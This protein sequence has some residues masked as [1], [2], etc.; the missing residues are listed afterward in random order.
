VFRRIVALLTLFAG[1]SAMFSALM[2][3]SRSLRHGSGV[4]VWL[5]VFPLVGL[6]VLAT[7]A[8]RR[9]WGSS[10]HWL[11][12]V[13]FLHSV[14]ALQMSRPYPQP[15]AAPLDYRVAAGGLAAIGLVLAVRWY[16]RLS[17]AGLTVDRGAGD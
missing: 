13:Y 17:L 14:I 3:A 4:G 11:A 9:L 10:S 8:A 7:W 16:R 12:S 1:C 6:A 5:P 15:D 2:L